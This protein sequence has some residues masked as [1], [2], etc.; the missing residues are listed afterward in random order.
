MLDDIT[1]SKTKGESLDHEIQTLL[2][3][4]VESLVIRTSKNNIEEYRNFKNIAIISAGFGKSSHPTQSI[5]D[6]ATL[7]KYKKLDVDIPIVFIGD[8]KHSRVYSSTKEL[9]NLLG[10]KVG[11]FTSEFFMPQEIEGCYIFSD[12][13]EVISSKSTINL[14]RVQSERIDNI[15]DYDLNEYIQSYQLTSKIIDR[16]SP[17]FMFLHPMPMNIGVEISKEASENIKFKYIEQL[18]LGVPARIASFLY[19]LGKI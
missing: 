17:D 19:A 9:L 4:G 2:S 12:W 11:I 10:F 1:S 7:L 18:A 15:E 13:E 6:V 14:L 5:L 8:V 3:L 16:T